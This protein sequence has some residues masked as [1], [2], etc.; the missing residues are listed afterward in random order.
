MQEKLLGNL[1]RKLL[2]GITDANLGCRPCNCPRNHKV[3]GVCAYGSNGYSC[4]TARTVYKITCKVNGCNCFYIGKSQQ[5]VNKQVQEHIGEVVKIYPKTI[6]PTNQQPAHPTS[7]NPHTSTTSSVE[8]SLD[9]QTDSVHESPPLHVIINN[10][11]P[12][13]PREAS[14]RTIRRNNSNNSSITNNRE[15]EPPRNLT[16]NPPPIIN[17]CPIE[18]PCDPPRSQ[19]RELLCS[20]LS[21]PLPHMPHPIQIDTGG[22]RV[23]PITHQCWHTLEIEHYITKEHCTHQTMP[24]MHGQTNDHRS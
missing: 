21:P 2:W 1:K 16:P 19:T 23:V 6:L 7:S 20:C 13:Q 11:A 8:L 14:T 24:S 15:N 9:K 3:N 12:N 10:N 4:W 5:Y 22:A 17:F 18:A